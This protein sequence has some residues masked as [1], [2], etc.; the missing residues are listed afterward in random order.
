[1]ATHWVYTV[2]DLY[3]GSSQLASCDAFPHHHGRSTA[4]NRVRRSAQYFVTYE[5]VPV[6]RLSFSGN[7]G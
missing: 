3:G 7:T 2:Y 1:M 5:F 4:L 6:M